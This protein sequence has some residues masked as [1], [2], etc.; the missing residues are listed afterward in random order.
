MTDRWVTFATTSAE[1]DPEDDTPRPI[2]GDTRMFDV[3]VPDPRPQMERA[4]F[5]RRAEAEFP[6]A[7]V[8]RLA[9]GELVIFTGWMQ[10]EAGDTVLRWGEKT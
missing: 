6:E 10:D 5:T 4:E 1:P 7:T 2:P 3:P 8:E 9:T